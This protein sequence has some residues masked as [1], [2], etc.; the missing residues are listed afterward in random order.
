[1][2]YYTLLAFLAATSLSAGDDVP[3]DSQKIIQ[4]NREFSET[5][6]TIKPGEKVVFKN[7]DDV[8]H[9]VFSNS[10][11]NPF[12]IKIQAPGSS[13]VVAFPDEGVTDVRCAIH[14]K[15]KLKVIVKK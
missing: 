7:T 4:K 9:N 11:V 15:M 10:K 2:R 5:E 12:T 14:P 3:G 13:S 1:M 6:I 8:T